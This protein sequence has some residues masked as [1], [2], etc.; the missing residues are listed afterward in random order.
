MLEKLGIPGS[1]TAAPYPKIRCLI[2]VSP[3][4]NLRM[5]YGISILYNILEMNVMFFFANP[6]KALC[7]PIPKGWGFT[8]YSLTKM[9]LVNG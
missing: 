1:A 3:S 9:W 5:P 2:A 6:T 4:V 8:A 7:I